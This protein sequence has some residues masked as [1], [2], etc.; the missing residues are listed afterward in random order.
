MSHPESNFEE[1]ADQLLAIGRQKTTG[2]LRV[3]GAGGRVKLFL[4]RQGCLADLHTGR[5]DS[6]LEAAIAA[7]GTL[8]EKDMKR[9]RKNAGKSGQPL[10]T[11]ILEL[12]VLDENVVPSAIR[13][14]LLEEICEVLHWEI[15]SLE[16]FEHGPDERIE[17]FQSE[18]SDLY[19]VSVET[20][21]VLLEAANRIGRWDLVLKTCN[22]LSDVFYATPSSFRY[23]RQQEIYPAEHAILS[24]VDGTKD[25]SEVVAESGLDPF[26]AIL[27]VRT[28]QSQGDLELINPVQMYQLAVECVSTGKTEKAAKLFQR[29]HER[30]LD[31]FD[32]VLKLAQSIDSLGRQAEAI[33]KYLE[34]AEKCISQHRMDDAIR[35]LRR[36]VK[37]DPLRFDAQEK[38]FDVLLEGNRGQETLEHAMALAAKKAELGDARGGL[39]VL[40]RAR[41]QFPRDQKLQQRI[42]ELAETCGE[43]QTARQERETLAKNLD[44]R[45][46]VELALETYQ[47]MFC[48]GNDGVEVRLKLV[49]LHRQRGNRQ[50]ALDHLNAVLGLPEKR[51]VKDEETLV[52][53]HETVREL[54]PSDI[55]SNRWLADYYTKKGEKEKCGQILT[56]W[57]Q[58][59]ETEGDLTEAV[60]AYEM[61]VSSSDTPDHRWG[62]AR[63][64]E[65]LGRLVECRREL[66]SLAN[67]TLRKKE[68]EPAAKA[69]DYI[70]KTAPLDLETRKMQAELHEAKEEHELASRRHEEIAILSIFSGNV[71]EAEGHC[72]RLDDKSPELAEAVRRLGRLCFEQGDRQKA[73]EQTIKAAKLH[74]QNRNFGLCEKAIE[75]LFQIEPGHPEG[76]VLQAELKVKESPPQP[77]QA[78]P[79]LLQPQPSQSADPM[80]IHT[81]QQ[82]QQQSLPTLAPPPAQT[83]PAPVAQAEKT[84]PVTSPALESPVECEPFQPSKPVVRSNVAGIMARLKK[85][86]SGGDSTAPSARQADAPPPESRG[87]AASGSQSVPGAIGTSGEAASQAALPLGGNVPN[88]ALRSAASRLKALAGKKAEQASGTAPPL[89]QAREPAPAPQ[90]SQGAPGSSTSPA[91]H[92]LPDFPEPIR[93]DASD[94]PAQGVNAESAPSAQASAAPE[95]T[96][97]GAAP[98]NDVKPLKLGKSASRLAALRKQPS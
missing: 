21:E 2:T 43:H 8:S 94:L 61:L 97:P 18:L 24:K 37:L 9:A 49:Q 58:C 76:K 33:Q 82:P 91:A 78:L 20:E 29:A 51:R 93:H 47:K 62:L 28:L 5:E 63:V 34:F 45:K 42:I 72:R 4:F 53:L 59:L 79:P 6:V 44:E 65:K 3:N 26:V 10:G 89:A 40:T 17:G 87:T 64:L 66:R 98:V 1:L 71:Q 80:Q 38:L 77:P 90:A 75:Q 32:I 95:A 19:D 81:I 31:D 85:L 25:V 83:A 48:D 74:I 92:E 57:I 36:V 69:L 55:R 73:A 46:D 12:G 39:N 7:S 67:L 96:P 41:Q 60:H 30:G 52:S 70:L 22:M 27:L 68:F 14:R 23:F 84:A 50:K 11:A 54:K 16:L 13:T 15:E 35:C 88:A 86:K 56:S